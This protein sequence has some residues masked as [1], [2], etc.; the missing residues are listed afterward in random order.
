MFRPYPVKKQRNEKRLF[1]TSFLRL[2]GALLIMI[3]LGCTAD[4]NSD[5]S[6]LTEKQEAESKP[7]KATQVEEGI[8]YTKIDD[9]LDKVGP[10]ERVLVTE[11]FSY[12][13]PH[14]A[15]L[16][17]GLK[18]WASGLPSYVEIVHTPAF[19]NEHFER[20]ARTYYALE[21]LKK[22]HELRD[23]IF[24]ELHTIRAKWSSDADVQRFVDRNGIDGEKFKK[25]MHSFAVKQK[26]KMAD[27]AFREYKL[28]SV[29]AFV[30]A[31]QY[32]TSVAQAGSEAQ[33]WATLNHL[34]AKIKA[35]QL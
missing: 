17:P 27:K 32:V 34:T 9:D 29:P 26:M 6:D 4:S 30:V 7:L 8:H 20:M 10:I 3:P 28:K 22:E 24:N 19:W 35:G 11:F 21:L 14:C 31:G 1:L 33:L 18:K 15:Y 12:G 5:S 16:E 13:C 2:I 23:I 25:T